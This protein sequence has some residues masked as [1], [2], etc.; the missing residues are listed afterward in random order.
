MRHDRANC[1]ALFLAI[2]WKLGTSA[3]ACACCPLPT[4]WQFEQRREA[5][6]RPFAGSGAFVIGPAK[7][8]VA[9]NKI[10]PTKAGRAFIMIRLAKPPSPLDRICNEEFRAGTHCSLIICEPILATF[11]CVLKEFRHPE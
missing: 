10:K 6:S 9:S 5:N 7:A 11:S 4:R 2:S 3:L 1:L 8:G